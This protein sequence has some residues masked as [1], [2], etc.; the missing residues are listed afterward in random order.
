[1]NQSG[2]QE[3]FN[4]SINQATFNS[5]NKQ[6]TLNKSTFN[7]SMIAINQSISRISINIQWVSQSINQ[8]INTQIDFQS[9][10]FVIS[11]WLFSLF[12]CLPIT[13]VMWQ[14]EPFWGSLWPDFET[15]SWWADSPSACISMVSFLCLC[16]LW[17]FVVMQWCS[18]HCAGHC[19]Y[20]G[21]FVV[22]FIHWHMHISWCH[23]VLSSHDHWLHT[24]IVSCVD[25][26]VVMHSINQRNNQP[27]KQSAI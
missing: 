12:V 4:R 27:T 2:V 13:L 3:Q 22:I 9:I 24:F 23:S 15:L 5:S 14:V 21:L 10:F 16:V 6:A 19:G 11:S 8:S 18:H 7:Q 20:L 26:T 17:M 1:M 25:C